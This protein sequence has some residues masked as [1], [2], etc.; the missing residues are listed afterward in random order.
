MQATV[1]FSHLILDSQELEATTSIWCREYLL[2]GSGRQDLPAFT[3]ILS[4][5][6]ICVRGR[7]LTCLSRG[8]SWPF[9]HDA[10]ACRRE[11]YRGCI[12]KSS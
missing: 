7:P 2:V 4:R 11:P 9:N 12:G 1:K 8:L 6:Q 5:H 3:P 10:S